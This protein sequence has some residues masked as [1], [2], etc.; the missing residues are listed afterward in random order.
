[1]NDS[2][3]SRQGARFVRFRAVNVLLLVLKRSGTSQ[4]TDKEY[5]GI[6]IHPA[7]SCSTPWRRTV[8][9]VT[10]TCAR[11]SAARGDEALASPPAGMR[12]PPTRQTP[13]F[14]KNLSGADTRGASWPR[15]LPDFCPIDQ[16]CSGIIIHGAKLPLRWLR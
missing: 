8:P 14:A 7:S 4:G 10:L 6:F 13:T 11:P 5:C 3:A 12:P 9:K 15:T 2:S 1:M 16:E